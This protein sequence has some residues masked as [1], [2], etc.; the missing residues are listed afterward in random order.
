MVFLTGCGAGGGETKK[1]DHLSIAATK[2][3]SIF[4]ASMPMGTESR[5]NAAMADDLIVK[6]GPLSGDLV[7]EINGQQRL[8][9]GVS[10]KQTKVFPGEMITWKIV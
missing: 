10:A 8:G 1:I 9:Q 2:E 3:E 7:F 6:I 4:D 5:Y